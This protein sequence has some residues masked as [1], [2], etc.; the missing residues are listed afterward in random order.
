MAREAASILCNFHQ[1]TAILHNCGL[2][3]AALQVQKVHL[4]GGCSASGK[5]RV[6]APGTQRAVKAQ[7]TRTSWR[8]ESSR[9]VRRFL[10]R[11]PEPCCRRG[12]PL[13]DDHRR[14]GEHKGSLPGGSER[15]IF[16]R[17]TGLGPPPRPRSARQGRCR[18]ALGG[19]DSAQPACIVR[20]AWRSRKMWFPDGL[21]PA[22]AAAPLIG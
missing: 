1:H 6:A 7:T 17:A 22:V 15:E 21:A 13:R 4:H 20:R 8:R 18:P 11:R 2:L 5:T 10:G 16:R 12:V 3:L 14:G 19:D 9:S